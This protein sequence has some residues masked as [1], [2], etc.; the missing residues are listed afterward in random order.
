[1]SKA[2]V[3]NVEDLGIQSATFEKSG[4][5]WT[6]YVQAVLDHVA[7]VVADA[8]GAE[9]YS[10]LAGTLTASRIVQIE[11]RLA[12]AELLLRAESIAVAKISGE[13]P[14]R[15]APSARMLQRQR[16]LEGADAIMAQM[17]LAPILHQVDQSFSTPPAGEAIS[18]SHFLQDQ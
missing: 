9:T 10:A 8:A 14:S 15:I 11:A 12:A 5:G 4:A 17:G 18:S 6:S 3:Q 1:M 7:L 2:T 13:D 16:L